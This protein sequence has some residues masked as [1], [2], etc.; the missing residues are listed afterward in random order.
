MASPPEVHS[1]L[2]SSGPGVASMIAAAGV[3]DSLSA[4]YASAAEE[5]DAL[6]AAVQAGAWQ[7]PSA[8][9]YVAA[10]VPY[11]A[12]LMQAST[13][14]AGAAA[15]HQAA[16]AAYTAA[17]AGMPTLAELAANHATH[18]ALVA[19]NFFGINTISIAL[20]E[21]DYVRMWVQAATTMATY[22]GV[23]G[24]AVAA[25]PRTTPAPRVQKDTAASSGNQDEGGGPTNLGWWQTRLGKVFGAIETDLA[26]FPSNPSGAVAQLLSDPVLVTELPH[27]AGEVAIT[28][29]PQLTQLTQLSAGLIAPYLPIGSAGGFA[30]LSGLAGLPQPAAAAPPAAPVPGAAPAAAPV[31][32]TTPGLGAPAAAPAPAPVSAPASAAAPATGGAPPATPPA[33]GAA[34]VGYPYL[35][36]PPGV[37]SGSPMSAGAGVMR[38]TPAPDDVPAAAGAAVGEP[39]RGRRRRAGLVDRGHRHEYLDPE[40]VAASDRGAGALG[41]A[42]TAHRAGADPAAGLT[43]LDAPAAPMTPNTWSHDADGPD[44]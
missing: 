24:A 22:Q 19:T 33:V 9:S 21:A 32:T 11:L 40:R 35:V 5:L 41:F 18:A 27:W 7:G 2:L 28:F 4:E 44:A 43:T 30:G 29:A 13:A 42:G 31:T 10:H 6:L 38:G 3:L 12:W 36:G 8:E 14:S 39:A 1:A 34:T 16:A 15:Q 26:A 37:G 17:L 25:T 23:S 20:N